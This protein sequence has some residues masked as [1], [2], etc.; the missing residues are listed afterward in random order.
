VSSRNFGAALRPGGRVALGFR[1]DTPSVPDRFRDSVYR[2]YSS[3]EV[4]AMF[5]AAG[6]SET[7][8][9]DAPNGHVKWV[10]AEAASQAKAV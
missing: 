3:S 4:M 1:P 5:K 2:F 10:I 9:Q 7:R 6:F 8:N